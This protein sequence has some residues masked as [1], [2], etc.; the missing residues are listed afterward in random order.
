MQ[1]SISDTLEARLAI[2]FLNAQLSVNYDAA[3]QRYA[4]YQDAVSTEDRRN[5]YAW[6]RFNSRQKGRNA[7]T[8]EF[9]F[10]KPR[11][12]FVCDH[13]GLLT[14][15][16]KH[17]TLVTHERDGAISRTPLT[18]WHDTTRTFR[19][20]SE[21]RTIVGN[22]A[23]VGDRESRIHMLV[24]DLEHAKPVPHINH[25]DMHLEEQAKE[26]AE[27]DKYLLGYL[28]AL[29][30]AGHHVLFLAPEFDEDEFRSPTR[31]SLTSENPPELHDIAGFTAPMINR[32]LS[33]LWYTSAFV[34]QQR[35]GFG[36]AMWDQ[37]TCL[38]GYHSWLSPGHEAEWH[39]SFIISQ[40]P[41]ATVLCG[42]EVI[43]YFTLSQISFYYSA[44]YTEGIVVR[45]EADYGDEDWTIA[46]VVDVTA[47]STGMTIR[48]DTARYASRF[49]NYSDVSEEHIAA[50]D[51]LITFFVEQ[52]FK[53]VAGTRLQHLIRSVR[54]EVIVTRSTVD[55]DGS[56]W[57][58]ERDSKFGSTALDSTIRHT[59]MHGFDVVVAI[60]QTS[61]NAQLRTRLSRIQE[62]LR[63]ER[64]DCLIEIKSVSVRLVYLDEPLLT[65]SERSRA[66]VT[67]HVSE[68]SLMSLVN[69]RLELMPQDQP[70]RFGECRLAFEVNLRSREHS[71]LHNPNYSPKPYS[72]PLYEPTDY[73]LHHIYL[74]L[75][76]A[77]HSPEYSTFDE[78]WDLDG[79]IDHRVQMTVVDRILK[80]Y[81]PELMS[82]GAHVIAS[83]PI[84]NHEAAP[85][86]YRLTS[87]AFRTYSD[88][89]V[90]IRDEAEASSSRPEQ[91]LFVLGM[92]ASGVLPNIK[93]FKPSA[94]W[95][96][97]A[98]AGFS[99]G[100]FA[101]S[102]STFHLRLH[103]LLARV[104][105]LTT[106]VPVS[107]SYDGMGGGR[108]IVQQW[109]KHKDF[110]SQS[111]DWKAVD[112]DDN[113]TADK[114]EWQYTREWNMSEEGTRLA[115][116]GNYF[117]SCTT[118]NELELPDV[119]MLS[120][121]SLEVRMSGTIKLR[122]ASTRTDNTWSTESSAFWKV[123]INIKTA[124]R[125]IVK[126]EVDGI[127][128]V[129]QLPPKTVIRRGS[130]EIPD[131]YQILQANL[132]QK[133][134][135]ADV[136]KELEELQG[137]WKYYYPGTSA[138]A[139]CSPMFNFDGDLLFEL[140]RSQS[141]LQ[142]SSTQ[143]GLG[144]PISPRTRASRSASPSPVSPQNGAGQRNQRPRQ[145]SSVERRSA[146]S[147][148]SSSP[149]P[150][151]HVRGRITPPPTRFGNQG[152]TSSPTKPVSDS[153][154]SPSRQGTPGLRGGTQNPPANVRRESTENIGGA[155]R[156]SNIVQN[157]RNG[158]ELAQGLR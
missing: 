153:P 74:N 154:S 129:K 51:M 6:A 41:R 62:L 57:M 23:K 79:F 93:T 16:I 84:Y 95:V 56:W 71:Q 103:S 54:N 139:L 7:A 98:S 90:A 148:R 65:E 128:N 105:A 27:L 8:L 68:G 121:G 21:R 94:R 133:E 150:S 130:A 82:H 50:R 132:P 101:I 25:R 147:S 126:V 80:E 83:V 53:L 106:L 158:K 55:S 42:R 108:D 73:A 28:K 5:S 67:V 22:D 135:F 104:N 19:I 115:V 127:D 40:P 43:L 122:I 45:S 48:A 143:N 91:I 78:S 117:V 36:Q 97:H 30:S 38:A 64:S 37:T 4:L 60:S 88:A 112:S 15:E 99:H 146:P 116:K 141:I 63:W 144:S 69:N 18:H 39:S 109:A 70:Y 125:G 77:Q 120:S 44:D 61:I 34:A 142:H 149:V 31:F 89:N 119:T 92:T 47:S 85:A 33:L 107:P 29:Q 81:L 100:T 35:K 14:L 11:L 157:V 123:S 3:L 75:E 86:F 131:A 2:D 118:H 96:V 156:L 26:Y 102:R 152:R 136:L 114:F 13:D 113:L 110:S 24:F 9:A 138:F 137:A 124:G 12:S 46:L 52:Y 20:T 76:H 10:R 1:T 72:Y 151:D 66:I 59:K 140:R 17:A 58:L 145:S 111:C 49:S 134:D 87:M 32:Y 155:A